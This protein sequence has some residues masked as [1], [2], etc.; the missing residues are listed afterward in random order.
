MNLNDRFDAVRAHGRHR[1]HMDPAEF[2]RD[3][4]ELQA[5]VA[6]EAREAEARFELLQA[7]LAELL[8]RTP[9]NT[10]ASVTVTVH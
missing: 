7:E 10:P 9:D 8:R 2:E 4:D 5:A 6:H 1:H 3:L